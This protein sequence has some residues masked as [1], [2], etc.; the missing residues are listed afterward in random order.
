MTSDGD[1]LELFLQAH[2]VHQ[3]A[4]RELDILGRVRDDAL[5]HAAQQRSVAE[6]AA[7]AGLAPDRVRR[8]LA[9]AR[10]S[11]GRSQH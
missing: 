10:R 11:L 4:R 7:E 9:A 8:Q 6:I 3:D 2:R 1:P 5:L